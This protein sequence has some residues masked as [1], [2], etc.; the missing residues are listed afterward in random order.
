MLSFESFTAHSF[1]WPNLVPPGRM[2]VIRVRGDGLLFPLWHCWL[3]YTR[4]FFARETWI[5]S[6]LE[7]LSTGALGPKCHIPEWYGKH[8]MSSQLQGER[9]KGERGRKY[10]CFKIRTSKPNIGDGRSVINK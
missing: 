7:H 10:N 3:S 6:L 1:P 4:V 2:L 5:F 9:N 8:P